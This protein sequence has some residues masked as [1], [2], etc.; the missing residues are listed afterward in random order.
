MKRIVTAIASVVVIA[1]V[2]VVA[3]KQL[4]GG[5]GITRNMFEEQIQEGMTYE[6]VVRITGTKG[7]P[8]TDRPNVPEGTELYTWGNDAR[9]GGGW[10]RLTFKDGKVAEKAQNGLP[11]TD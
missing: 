2:V 10:M 1:A 9:Q 5:P 8:V 3:Y 11:N 4:P 7:T 6:E